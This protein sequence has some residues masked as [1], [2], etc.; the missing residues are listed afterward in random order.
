MSKKR[1]KKPDFWMGPPK[2]HHIGLSHH[3]PNTRVFKVRFYGPRLRVGW[4]WYQTSAFVANY[5]EAIEA[6]EDWVTT[7]KQYIEEMT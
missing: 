3:Y 1:K 2:P 4:G 7:T 5:K 6:F